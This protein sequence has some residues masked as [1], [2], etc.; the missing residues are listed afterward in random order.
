M[1]SRIVVS[2]PT[3]KK[4]KKPGCKDQK[5]SIFPLHSFKETASN[6]DTIPTTAM[7]T[8]VIFSPTM[9]INFLLI[10]TTDRYKVPARTAQE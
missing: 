1:V 2:F 5:G 10:Q 9:Q 6:T 3:H 8:T 4:D 7:D